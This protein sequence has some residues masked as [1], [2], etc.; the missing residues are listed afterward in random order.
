MS[1]GQGSL[2]PGTMGWFVCGCL[3]VFGRGDNT[4]VRRKTAA[5]RDFDLA[6]VAD[7]SFSSDRHAADAPA[8]SASP[9]I[10]SDLWH[11]SEMTR[12]ATPAVSNCSRWRL[13]DHLVGAC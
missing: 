6:Y 4:S 1:G 10:A 13:F 11:R 5:L 12:G 2:A 3:F 7:G 8:M 9:P